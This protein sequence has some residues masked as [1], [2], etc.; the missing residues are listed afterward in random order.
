[1]V[2]I[3]QCVPARTDTTGL[4]QDWN[5]SLTHGPRSWQVCTLR[6]PMRVGFAAPTRHTHSAIIT[7]P[8]EVRLCSTQR[9]LGCRT[10]DVDLPGTQG[11]WSL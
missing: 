4:S 6:C 1:M 8:D 7:L 11:H 3:D 9:R 10:H 5:S 2:S